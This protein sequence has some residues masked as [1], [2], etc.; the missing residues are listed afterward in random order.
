MKCSMTP[1]IFSQFVTEIHKQSFAI[2]NRYMSPVIEEFSK[3]LLIGHTNMVPHIVATVKFD[4]VLENGVKSGK[5]GLRWYKDCKEVY[6]LTEEELKRY[7]RQII[8]RGFGVE[9]QEKLKKAKVFIAGSGGLGSPIAYYLAAA[10]IGTLRI[11]DNDKI[12]LSNLN[13]QILHWEKDISR[14]KVDSA[15]EK[16]SQLNHNVKIEALVETID[17]S[18]ISRLTEGF[19]VIVDAMDNLPTRFLLNKEAVERRIPFIHGA[20]RG[21]EGRVMT[22]IPGETA[23]LRCIYRSNIP[24]EKFP[25]LGFTPGVIGCIQAAETVKFI[26][27]MGDLLKNRMLVYDGLSMKFTELTVKKNPECEVCGQD[28]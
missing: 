24:K 7:D 4:C 25:V 9:G 19:D 5:T 8:T 21:F 12:E 2:I 14:N 11:I 10:G 27:G 20:V 26:V 1:S 16:L 17:E 18:S 13:R 22:V 6:M 23:C 3:E 28:I 15:A